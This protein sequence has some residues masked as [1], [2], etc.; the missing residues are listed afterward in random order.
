MIIACCVCGN[1]LGTK[2]PYGKRSQE[3]IHTYCEKCYEIEMAKLDKEED[4]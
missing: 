4:M 2:E 3:I 1:I